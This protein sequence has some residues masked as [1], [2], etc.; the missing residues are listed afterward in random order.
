MTDCCRPCRQVGPT[1]QIS[2]VPSKQVSAKPMLIDL[3]HSCR[4]LESEKLLADGARYTGEWM[5]AMRDGEGRQVWPS[6]AEYIGQ[7]LN[8]VLEGKGQYT[9][10][11]GSVY[12][13]EWLN[14]KHHG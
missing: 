14:E 3:A 7:W 6:G 11:D 9:Y 1:P 10:L 13:G 2:E 12:T 5:G 4:K 8:D